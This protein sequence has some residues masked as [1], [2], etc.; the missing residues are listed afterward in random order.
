MN[1]DGFTIDDRRML[2][3]VARN[4]QLRAGARHALE[5]IENGNTELAAAI[6]R[7]LLDTP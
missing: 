1:L 3:A 6:L 2:R 7:D 4:A 5:A